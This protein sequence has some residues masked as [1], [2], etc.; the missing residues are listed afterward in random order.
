MNSSRVTRN[1][2][3][4]RSSVGSELEESHVMEERLRD[5]LKNAGDQERPPPRN[6]FNHVQ[7]VPKLRPSIMT[8]AI[9]NIACSTPMPTNKKGTF[10][11]TENSLNISPIDPIVEEAEKNLSGIELHPQQNTEGS[12]QQKGIQTENI[13]W[14]Q[15]VKVVIPNTSLTPVV[16]SSD[17][18]DDREVEVLM[19][20]E[21]NLKK[22]MVTTKQCNTRCEEKQQTENIP[23][24]IPDSKH[25]EVRSKIQGNGTLTDKATKNEV[26]TENI[27]SRGT[28]KKYTRKQIKLQSKPTTEPLKDVENADEQ[29]K[30]TLNKHKS[31]NRT[32][33]TENFDEDSN[34]VPL[35]G[36]QKENLNKTNIKSTDFNRTLGQKSKNTS[37][38]IKDKSVDLTREYSI[39]T[40]SKSSLSTSKSGKPEPTG[41]R[42]TTPLESHNDVRAPEEVDSPSISPPREQMCLEKDSAVQDPKTASCRKTRS[43]QKTA[44]TCH[45]KKVNEKSSKIPIPRSRSKSKEKNAEANTEACQAPEE[46]GEPDLNAR[47]DVDSPKRPPRRKQL[48]YKPAGSEPVKLNKSHGVRID[49]N[50][51]GLSNHTVTVETEGYN[52]EPI[53]GEV[54]PIEKL[55]NSSI[56]KRNEKLE[57]GASFRKATSKDVSKILNHTKRNNKDVSHLDG[58]NSAVDMQTINRGGIRMDSMKTLVDIA[59][60]PLVPTSEDTGQENA[61]S[62]EVSEARRSNLQHINSL[63]GIF[64]VTDRAKATKLAELILKIS[65]RNM[66]DSNVSSPKSN[67]RLTEQHPPMSN[68]T[69]VPNDRGESKK[70]R[71]VQ[72]SLENGNFAQAIVERQTQTTDSLLKLRNA[73]QGNTTLTRTVAGFDE[74]DS[75]RSSVLTDHSEFIEDMHRR[76]GRKK[77]VPG[78]FESLP[79]V[80]SINVWSSDDEDLE[81]TLLDNNR[82]ERPWRLDDNLQILPRRSS[83]KLNFL[84]SVHQIENELLSKK[85]DGITQSLLENVSRTSKNKLQIYARKTQYG[86]EKVSES[87]APRRSVH[88][89][90]MSS[91]S[92]SSMSDLQI[93]TSENNRP[94]LEEA[95]Q[96]EEHFNESS[97]ASRRIIEIKVS[98][99]LKGK[100]PVKQVEEVNLSSEASRRSP[101]KLVDGSNRKTVNR[102]T[103]RSRRFSCVDYAVSQNNNNDD[104]EDEIL[105]VPLEDSADALQPVDDAVL[106]TNKLPNKSRILEERNLSTNKKS[107]SQNKEKEI[108]SP[109]ELVSNER[110]NLAARKSSPKKKAVKAR[111]ARSKRREIIVENTDGV[112]STT[113]ESEDTTGVRRSKRE[114]KAVHRPCYGALQMTNQRLAEYYSSSVMLSSI[115]KST[116]KKSTKPRTKKKE[117]AEKNANDEGFK[118]PQ[119]TKGKRGMKK[120]NNVE[121]DLSASASN[122]L[123]SNQT[124][125]HAGDVGTSPRK[126]HPLRLDFVSNVDDTP[127]KKCRTTEK[128]ISAHDNANK[129]KADGDEEISDNLSRNPESSRVPNC[130]TNYLNGNQAPGNFTLT[131]NIED[132]N[133]YNNSS[134]IHEP[135]ADSAFQS[136][137]PQDNLNSGNFLSVNNRAWDKDS[138]T[139]TMSKCATTFEESNAQVTR[140]L[141][142]RVKK[143]YKKKSEIS[144]KIAKVLSRSINT[145]VECEILN[146]SEVRSNL[147]PVSVNTAKVP[148]GNLSFALKPVDSDYINLY[149]NNMLFSMK[150]VENK[151]MFK[152]VPNNTLMV[153]DGIKNTK[154][155]GSMGFLKL[156]PSGQKP[157]HITRKFA[158][159]YLVIKGEGFI[160]VHN[161]SSRVN[162][163][164]S[165]FV[166]LGVEYSIHNTSKQEELILSFVKLPSNVNS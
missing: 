162:E 133:Y 2:R 139:S 58:G 20:P 29:E 5:L 115:S 122:T 11:C 43:A 114:R 39:K 112:S 166:P 71:T 84:R 108:K 146:P 79:P 37:K 87:F 49:E 128:R 68:S 96:V 59:T 129:S 123:V 155:G 46:F 14:G 48:K 130:S 56:Q 78:I 144:S 83:C 6:I 17:S 101:V 141:T 31:D 118:K 62:K 50:R 106:S 63:G 30:D 94:Q 100:S 13:I 135:S 110:S 99:P 1:S 51:A 89:R 132:N 150:Y 136:N 81:S 131:N 19:E 28:E 45:N 54:E 153:T 42:A 111:T 121:A 125:I 159:F 53:D 21:R 138:G 10:F 74:T 82:R 151:P 163:L 164:S 117:V 69:D 140:P 65:Q 52:V 15:Q 161:K 156:P 26:K 102:R 98:S 41:K 104:D 12:Q 38:Y 36:H 97:A 120:K 95:Q 72:T 23:N 55:T 119:I 24:N 64:S 142:G 25:T 90:R 16:I 18:E 149:A 103:P 8:R 165:F 134:Q 3:R 113:V 158:L 145:S 33:A 143:N 75:S 27:K 137:V 160:Q 91:S 109:S 105:A 44:D 22:N 60:S 126:R 86:N 7:E 73:F 4:A 47:R 148:T 93:A 77:S 35:S 124:V 88:R 107:T 157:L 152:A 116:V 92:H 61:V 80:D 127:N 57:D 40:R 9:Q 32:G 67:V 34:E 76:F 70:N 85:C 147:S 154:D 66:E